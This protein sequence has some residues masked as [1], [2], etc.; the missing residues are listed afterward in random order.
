MYLLF[1][2]VASLSLFFF[3]IEKVI[4]KLQASYQVSWLAKFLLKKKNPH[5]AVVSV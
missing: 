4:Q 5:M 1:H 3:L 2:K